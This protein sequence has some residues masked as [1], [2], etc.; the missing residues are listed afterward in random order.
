MCTTVWTPLDRAVVVWNA[1]PDEI[2]CLIEAG[3]DVNARGKDGWTPLHRAASRTTNPEIITRLVEAGAELEA[4]NKDD[5]TPLHVAARDGNP[6][7]ITS[8]LELGADP[9]ARDTAGRTPLDRDI[10]NTN[11]EVA[12]QL[13]PPPTIDEQWDAL[14][15]AAGEEAV[16]L[17]E[18]IIRERNKLLAGWKSSAALLDRG[19]VGWGKTA[20][21]LKSAGGGLNS[22]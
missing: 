12:A 8:H 2:S 6:D 18:N 7:T 22:K 10:G 19:I 17:K 13:A 21:L 16:E 11:P 5:N 1:S 4:K 9:A 20:D 3:A 14:C 15:S